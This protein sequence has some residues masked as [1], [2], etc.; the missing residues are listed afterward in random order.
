MEPSPLDADTLR[1]PA[2]VLLSD[3]LPLQRP[4]DSEALKRH[5]PPVPFLARPI[6]PIKLGLPRNLAPPSDKSAPIAR[7][8]R[9]RDISVSERMRAVSCNAF[10]FFWMRGQILNLLGQVTEVAPD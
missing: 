6:V 9:R 2:E 1:G 5:T 10:R 4:H 7:L 8:R 3:R